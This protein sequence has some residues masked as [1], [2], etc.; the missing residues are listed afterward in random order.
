M[1]LLACEQAH[2]Y[3]V[4]GEY[5]GGEAAI[6]RA[7]GP[8]KISLGGFDGLRWRLYRQDTHPIPQTLDNCFIDVKNTIT[9]KLEI[10][11]LCA[12]CPV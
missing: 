5:F 10:R 8:E 3:G 7:M 6:E 1:L 4:S 2:L 11:S 12:L 9:I